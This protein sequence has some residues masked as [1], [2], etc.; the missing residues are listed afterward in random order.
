MPNQTII[1]LKIFYVAVK[2]SKYTANNT[3]N[4]IDLLSSY[5]QVNAYSWE[6]NGV[7]T[8]AWLPVHCKKPSDAMCIAIAKML[9]VKK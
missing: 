4:L 6:N 5:D 7:T 9:N 1:F 3:H 2:H 8:T